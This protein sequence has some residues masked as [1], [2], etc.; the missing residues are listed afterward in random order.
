MIKICKSTFYSKHEELVGFIQ[1]IKK[2]DV[3][4]G[5][6]LEKLNE[7]FRLKN[8]V[9]KKPPEPYVYDND[10]KNEEEYQM[11]GLH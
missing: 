7:L 4:K 6:S 2:I 1:E 11:P 9:F 10:G 8:K 5:L 3:I